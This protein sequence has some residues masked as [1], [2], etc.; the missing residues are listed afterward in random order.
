MTSDK[1][2]TISTVGLKGQVVLRKAMRDAVHIKPGMPV[3]Q[4]VTLDGILIRPVDTAEV[5]RMIGEVET[6]ARKVSKRWK[7]T[8]AVAAISEDRD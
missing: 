3:R 6:L 8:S 7:G 1:G 2:S 4:Q 5:E